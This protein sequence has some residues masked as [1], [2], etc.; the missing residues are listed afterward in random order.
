[1]KVCLLSQIEADLVPVGEPMH[2][3]RSWAYVL[4]GDAR[5]F[6]SVISKPDLLGGYDVIL[7]ELTANAYTVPPF[8]RQ[9]APDAILVG[10]VEGGLEQVPSNPPWEQLAFIECI[11]TLDLLGVL[12]EDALP[13]YRLLAG[14]DR[15]VQW[16][17]IPYPKGWT[18]TVPK[19]PADAKVTVIELGS[20]LQDGRNGLP[21]ILL[22]GRIR[23]RHPH[24]RGRAYGSSLAELAPLHRLDP[25]LELCVRRSWREYY[26]HHVD[27]Y[28]MLS[29]DPRRTWGR[30]V[31]DCASA[32]VP[33]VGSD[34]THC[35]RRVGVLTCD[36]YDVEA[37]FRHV[38]RLLDDP[39][40]YA[41]VVRR[42]YERLEAYGEEASRG[43]FWRAL[44]LA[45]AL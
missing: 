7:V 34:A 38:C 43:R 35:G 3:I 37:A 9:H 21:S 28:A 15:R 14:E 18:D 5:G 11:R 8:V 27:A 33:Y 29:F 32:L 23:K 30:L 17:G 26:R 36:P 22:L 13:Y 45:D 39:G 40:L 10:L 24:V 25:T 12:V 44:E 2:E 1:V 41:A 20:T 4:G 42:Q 19:P 16:L 6:G 31:L